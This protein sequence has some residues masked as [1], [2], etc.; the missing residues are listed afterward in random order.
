[1]P[2]ARKVIATVTVNGRSYEQALGDCGKPRCTR[3][4]PPTGRAPSHGPY[5]YLLGYR[6]GGRS[7]IYLGKELD[8]T[9]YASPSGGIDWTAVDQKKRIAAGI[10]ETTE[11]ETLVDLPEMLKGQDAYALAE[12]LLGRNAT[13]QQLAHL[14]L[15]LRERQRALRLPGAPIHFHEDTDDSQ[16]PQSALADSLVLPT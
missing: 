3:C 5:W 15:E 4:N 13:E 6:N 14:A 8:T 1:M 9:R 16:E 10:P 11:N 12:I 2:K 7:R